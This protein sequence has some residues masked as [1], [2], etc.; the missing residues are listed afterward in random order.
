MMRVFA[1]FSM[2]VSGESI[3]GGDVMAIGRTIAMEGT[4]ITLAK[5]LLPLFM[6]PLTLPALC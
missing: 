3:E 5:S 2:G 4:R 6:L 1:C